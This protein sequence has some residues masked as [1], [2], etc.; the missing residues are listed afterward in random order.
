MQLQLMMK[1]AVALK[2]TSGH[3]SCHTQVCPVLQI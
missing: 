1:E 2:I 3:S